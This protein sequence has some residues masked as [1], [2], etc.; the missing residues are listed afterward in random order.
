MAKEPVDDDSPVFGGGIKKMQFRD[1]VIFSQKKATHSKTYVGRLGGR[2]FGERG[3]EAPPLPL[4]PLLGHVVVEFV[5]AGRR[6][7]DLLKAF[8]GLGALDA[9]G[10]EDPDEAVRVQ[11]GRGGAGLVSV[12][13]TKAAGGARLPWPRLPTKRGQKRCKIRL[14]KRFFGGG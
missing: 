5:E 11:R 7:G 9:V 13:R 12:G 6:L 14:A 8:G 1:N 10:T 3:V 2:G 4:L